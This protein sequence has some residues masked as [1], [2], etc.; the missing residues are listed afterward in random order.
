[1]FIESPGRRRTSGRDRL[2]TIPTS[3]PSSAASAAHRQRVFLKS[4]GIVAA[5]VFLSRILGF[6]REWAIAHQVGS[7]AITDVYYA[8]FT[9][10]DFLNYLLAGGALSITFLPVFL[11]YFTS[12][13]EEEGWRVFSIVISA[14]SLLLLVLIIIAEIFASQLTY[15]IAPGFNPE[16]HRLVTEL[17]RILLP[18]QAFFFIGGVLSAVQYA[19]GRFLIPSLA[20]L[21]YNGFIIAFGMLLARWWGIT[22]FCW[23][24][25]AG[26]FCGNFLMQV[27]GV[28]RLSARY[29]WSLDVRHPGFR[30][31]M[32]LSIPIMLGFSLIFIDD[33][34]IRWF[35]S[36]LVPASITWLNYG[37][38]LMRV[39][40]SIFAQS[41]GVAAFPSLA[42]F[43][44]EKKWSE[45]NDGLQSA[46]N[47]LTA[48]RN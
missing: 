6:F 15:W 27:W 35:G 32:R 44:A 29:R 38:I 10:P 45:M 1:M 48:I 7:N 24:V 46:L 33:W 43:A 47:H 20:P 11:E 13:R 18:A 21:I 41:A 28:S 12:Q 25:V 19:Q 2:P 8:A 42:R 23:G 5:S 30:R 37:K 26:S 40:V 17:T 22:A 36:F 39:A 3:D 34:A 4:A 9:I 31:F 14:T 16:Q